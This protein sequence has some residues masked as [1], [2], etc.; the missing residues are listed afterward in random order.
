LRIG[1]ILESADALE[2]FGGVGGVCFESCE[3]VVPGSVVALG[4]MVLPGERVG[5]GEVAE[6]GAVIVLQQLGDA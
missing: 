2:E 1:R 4:A 6:C 3:C 5:A